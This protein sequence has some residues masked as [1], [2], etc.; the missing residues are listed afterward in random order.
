LGGAAAEEKSPTRE[1]TG[2]DAFL[3]FRKKM[4]SK[5]DQYFEKLERWC[6]LKDTPENDQ[7]LTSLVGELDD[8]WWDMTEDEQAEAERR[9]QP[10]VEKTL[11]M[12]K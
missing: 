2:M 12:L 10:L 5:S 6:S 9:A 7:E 4:M 11:E 1:I 3:S 8:L